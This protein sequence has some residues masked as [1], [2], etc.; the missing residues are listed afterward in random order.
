VDPRV[1]PEAG[2][3]KRNAGLAALGWLLTGVALGFVGWQLTQG[4]AWQLAGDRLERLAPAV[5]LGALAYAAASFLLAEAWRQLLGANAEPSPARCYYAVYGRTQ[6]VK[7]LPGNLFH[8][9]GRQIMGR[10]LRHGQ[11]T[12]ALASIAEILLLLLV[13]TALAA[14]LIPG[15]LGLDPAVAWPAA[16]LAI[17]IA[18]AAML[19]IRL[20]IPA[21]PGTPP[22]RSPVQGEGIR[23]TTGSGPSLAP[24]GG[25]TGWRG[26]LDWWRAWTAL[27]TPP[28]LG[29][30][31]LLYAAFFVIGGVLLWLLTLAAGGPGPGTPGLPISISALALAW[32]AG[33]VT[34]GLSAGFGVREAVLIVVLQSS[35]DREAG[36]LVALALR[37]VTLAGDLLFFTASL[38]LPLPDS[39]SRQAS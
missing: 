5:L 17:G 10:R 9:A 1:R 20:L 21:A 18:I 30:A 2:R 6:I 36:V 25:G 7:Y 28:Q 3:R 34:P 8:F 12:L 38:T 24:W 29:H 19:T 33:F 15:W 32:I 39:S 27:I 14:P 16:A 22:P 11:A 13:A 35:L 26:R 23:W 31:A 4:G 37:L